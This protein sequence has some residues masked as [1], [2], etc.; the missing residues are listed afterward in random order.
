LELL[1]P[2]W[3]TLEILWGLEVNIEK[4]GGS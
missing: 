3:P 1:P 2:D 4:R